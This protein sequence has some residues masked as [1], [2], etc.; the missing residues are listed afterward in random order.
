MFCERNKIVRPVIYVVSNQKAK[1]LAEEASAEERFGEL[2]SI[3]TADIGYNE[4]SK[5]PKSHLTRM[6]ASIY[7]AHIEALEDAE[8]I[9]F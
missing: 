4:S 1:Y 7:S 3:Q 5:D 6:V 2:A 8:L 9:E